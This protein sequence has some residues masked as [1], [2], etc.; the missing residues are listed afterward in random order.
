M[1]Q[2]LHAVSPSVRSHTTDNSPTT[3]H[4]NPAKAQPRLHCTLE[5]MVGCVVPMQRP[6]GGSSAGH[7]TQRGMEELQLVWTCHIQ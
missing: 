1:I 4:P 2:C 3:R 5:A 6:Q 7:L